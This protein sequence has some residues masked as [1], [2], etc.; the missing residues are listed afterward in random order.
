MQYTI[1]SGFFRCLLL[2]I[3]IICSFLVG[4]A[5]QDT[6]L[7]VLKNSLEQSIDACD[8]ESWF[9]SV[10]G[11]SDTLWNRG[12][13][14]WSCAFLDSAL[15]NQFITFDEDTALQYLGYMYQYSAFLHY[16][17]SD[18]L[19]SR[20]QYLECQRIF[21]R[22]SYPKGKSDFNILFVLGKI[23]HELGDAKA[24]EEYIREFMDLVNSPL[25]LKYLDDS[26]IKLNRV[27]GFTQLGLILGSMDNGYDSA[28]VN[29][30]AALGISGE[31]PEEEAILLSNMGLYS[32]RA[33][34]FSV[35][36]EYIDQSLDLYQAMSDR[37]ELTGNRYQQYLRTLMF[38]GEVLYEMGFTPEAIDTYNEA[39]SLGYMYFG[40]LDY[41]MA[42]SYLMLGDLYYKEGRYQEAKGVLDSAWYSAVPEARAITISD[43]EV[44]QIVKADILVAE[45]LILRGLNEAR[46]G[47]QENN[48]PLKKQAIETLRLLGLTIDQILLN[49]DGEDAK[50]ILAGDHHYYAEEAIGLALNIYSE[51]QDS[52]YLEF[53]YEFCKKSKSV[54]ML[55]ALKN[56]QAWK[57]ADISESFRE[58]EAEL[59]QKIVE[60]ESSILH[61]GDNVEPAIKKE[62]ERQ[63]FEKKKAYKL[64]MNQIER[65]FPSYFQLKL[66]WQ[67]HGLEDVQEI[68]RERDTRLLEYYWGEEKAYIIFLDGKSVFIHEFQR[69]SVNDAL[70]LSFLKQVGS[71]DNVNTG[72]DPDAFRQFADNSYQLKEYLLGP[73]AEEIS[74]S[75]DPLIIIPDGPLGFLPFEILLTRPYLSDKVDYFELPYLVKDLVIG[76]EY[77]SEFLNKRFPR[78]ESTI[79]YL[80]FAPTYSGNITAT[81][82][83]LKHNSR[84]VTLGNQIFGGASVLDTL[85]TLAAFWTQG[86]K[87]QILHLA[88]HAVISEKNPMKSG[89]YFYHPGADPLQGN[90]QYTVRSIDSL[91]NNITS[92]ILYAYQIAGLKLNADHAILSACNTG[93]GELVDGEGIMSLGRAFSYAGCPSVLMSLWKVDDEKTPVLMEYYFNFLNEGMDKN[94]ALREAKLAYLENDDRSHPFFWA[95]FV[96]VGD[97]VPIRD[98]KGIPDSCL[99]IIFAAFLAG[100]LIA[101]RS[102]L[103]KNEAD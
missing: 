70:L 8:H 22:T 87:S 11:Y 36:K 53:A 54:S 47:L 64:L 85:A 72:N 45:I 65:E 100:G 68:L 73:V 60:Y 34:K 50:Q 4:K 37:N 14:E 32:I 21:N 67:S 82:G 43:G 46:L 74:R 101:F 1:R 52:K 88:M 96:Q 2:Q 15:G 27:R 25:A 92:S 94:S 44:F 83:Q 39:N 6:A 5:Q 20:D 77:S 76:Y 89:L 18:F 71:P 24:G 28:M 84:E 40:G 66:K 75:G 99:L 91:G 57:N 26:G 95:G 81:L 49:V 30:N 79:P 33:D 58:A 98:S 102:F 59:R 69:E 61:A 42:P 48:L 97:P 13:L 23:Y 62:W 55:D 12:E 93:V 31:F 86:E 41:H 29:F 7:V 90:K 38:R 19:T 63:L 17:I 10:R 16:K 78:D 51:T 56:E 80:G 3:V 9:F 103:K 35:A